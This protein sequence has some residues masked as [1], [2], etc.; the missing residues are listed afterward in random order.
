[1]IPTL[2]MILGFLALIFGIVLLFNVIIS[3]VKVQMRSINGQES[4]EE[5][6]SVKRTR[7]KDREQMRSKSFA[8]IV[9]GAA[10][11]AAGWYWGYA[12]K[13]EGFWFHKLFFAN[14]EAVECWDKISDDGKYISDSG[15][16]YTYYLLVKENEY[17]FCGEPCESIDE[18]EEKLSQIKRE[19]TVMLIDSFAVASSFHAAE[20]LLKKIP[21]NYEV[22]EV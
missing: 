9:I 13:G 18:V 1:M 15:N 17:E 21:I 4:I 11:F 3:P 12:E 10:V 20:E 22:E 6:E 7:K 19:N 16:V 14:D 5:N 8:I 2:L